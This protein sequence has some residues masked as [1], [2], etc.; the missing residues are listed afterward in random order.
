MSHYVLHN[1]I[2]QAHLEDLQDRLSQSLAGVPSQ[3][4]GASGADGLTQTV[5]NVV[6]AMDVGLL[7]FEEVR[8][9]LS[10]LH[11][12]GFSI[13]RWMDEMVDEGVYLEV[14]LAQAA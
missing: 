6:R 9:V 4:H 5:V 13:E 14:G 1:P 12:S 11:I 3:P 8:A 2:S 7:S 10:P